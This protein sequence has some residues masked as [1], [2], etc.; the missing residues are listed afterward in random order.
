MQTGGGLQLLDEDGSV[1]DLMKREGRKVG[2]NLPSPHVLIVVAEAFFP[3]CPTTT[4]LPEH[5]SPFSSLAMWSVE[6]FTYHMDN[7]FG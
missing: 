1:V 5:C 7:P 3:L 6:N 4:W 2:K